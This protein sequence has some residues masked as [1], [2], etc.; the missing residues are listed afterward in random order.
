MNRMFTGNKMAVLAIGACAASIAAWQPSSAQARTFVVYQCLDEQDIIPIREAFTQYWQEQHNE[1]L[2]FQDFF[3]PCGELR[4]T[5]E[6]EVRGNA[7]QADVLIA[8]IGDFASIN[9]RYPEMFKE[10]DPPALSDPE[11]TSTVRETAARNKNNFMMSFGPYVLVYNTDRVAPDEVPESWADLLSPRWHGRI[12]MGDPETTAGAHVPLWFIVKYLGDTVGEPFGRPYYAELGKNQPITAGSHGAI[13]EFVNAGELDVG[14]LNLSAA[15][16]SA[17]GGNHVAAV[18]P[19]EGAGALSMSAGV[20]ADT[21]VSDVAEAFVNWLL[22]KPGQEAVYIGTGA[23]PI[24]SD[25][26]IDAMPFPFD[27]YSELI[28][29][30]DATWIAENRADNIAY[31]REVVK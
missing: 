21:D 19:K 22:T 29:P 5:V 23:V 7:V 13:V 2:T 30:I 9:L 10:F 1:T 16:N 11:I 18:L 27:L 24:R 14:I 26:E 4:A 15:R 31:F 25:V 17:F 8:D 28:R 3:Q 20:I 6:L 12:G